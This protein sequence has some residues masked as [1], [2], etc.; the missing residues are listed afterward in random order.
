MKETYVK[1]SP[2]ELQFMLQGSLL[3]SD[4]ASQVT[5]S[6]MEIRKLNIFEKQSAFKQ[7][8]HPAYYPPE[9]DKPSKRLE[10]KSVIWLLGGVGLLTLSS[11]VFY[12]ICIIT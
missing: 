2:E 10:G 3:W 11:W 8:G 1:L 7:A 12:V 9:K 4:V 6:K 5:T